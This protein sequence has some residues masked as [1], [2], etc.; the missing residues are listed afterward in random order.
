MIRRFISACVV[1]A[2]TFTGLFAQGFAATPKKDTGPSLPL[3]RDAEIEGLLRLYSRPIFKAAGLNP[4]AVH[5]YIINNDKIN[6]FVAN[7]QRLFVHTGLLMRTKTPN[8]LIGVLAHETGHIAG[9]HLAR[10]GNELDKASA[11]SIV[12]MLIGMAAVVGGSIAGQQGAAQAG[13]GIVM[14]SQG[15]AQRGFLAY[16]RDMEAS[17]DNAALKFLKA[18]EQ[19]PKGMLDLFQLLANESLASTSDQDPY[20]FSH[21]MPMERIRNLE[22]AAKTSIYFD[23]PDPPQLMLRHQLM[24]AKLAGFLDSPQA[25]FQRYPSSDDSLPSRYAR[26]IAMFRKGDNK[27]A[28][29]I[30]D[31][32]IRDLPAD[33][34][35]WELKGQALLEGGQAGQALAPLKQAN[36]LLPNSGLL[37]ILYAQALLATDSNANASLALS[38]L[39]RAKRTEADTAD[40]YKYSAIA[41]GKLGDVPR[42]ELSTAEAALAQGDT[43]LA[44]EKAKFAAGQFK[45]GSAEWLKANDILNFATKK[46]D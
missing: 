41:Y 34:Y 25:V 37:Q 26:S 5:V 11:K 6:A 13:Q 45:H 27:N 4:S 24:Q 15:L 19:S 18:T 46:Q 33:P 31:S 42:A 9:G 43:T 30:M 17:A 35:F 2:M 40:V 29:P 1:F 36:T 8:E 7:G 39:I 3:I 12:G 22:A 28:I 10:M 32:L 21:P 16:Q 14:G 23:K 38:L 20:L 44:V